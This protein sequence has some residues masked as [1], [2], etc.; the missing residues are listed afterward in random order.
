MP[1]CQ[2]KAP[3]E[4]EKCLARG[5]CNPSPEPHSSKGACKEKK[6][7]ARIEAA[8]TEVRQE[9]AAVKEQLRQ[10][11]EKADDLDYLND[12]YVEELKDLEYLNGEYVEELKYRRAC[13][14]RYC[15]FT[16]FSLPT[17]SAGSSASSRISR[18]L[19]ALPVSCI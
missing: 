4:E 10:T 1:S 14:C 19:E 9:L 18:K 17:G 3:Y 15:T 16:P 11:A 2:A 8:T 13:H 5:V 7:K 12:E 6:I